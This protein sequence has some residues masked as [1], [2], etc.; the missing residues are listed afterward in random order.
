MDFMILSALEK[1]VIIKTAKALLRHQ[2]EN[3]AM[4]KGLGTRDRDCQS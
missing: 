3:D 4:R 1:R 2:K